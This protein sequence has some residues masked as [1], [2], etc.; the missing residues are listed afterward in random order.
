MDWNGWFDE[1]LLYLGG[2]RTIE[3]VENH[4]LRF[5]R[6]HPLN[7]SGEATLRQWQYDR[8]GPGEDGG[9]ALPRSFET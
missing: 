4:C 8:G 2:C 7:R 1:A 5:E 9:L 6:P 3:E